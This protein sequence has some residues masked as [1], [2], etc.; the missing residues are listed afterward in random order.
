M[1]WFDQ[2]IAINRLV[3]FFKKD[4][5]KVEDFGNR[6]NQTFEAATFAQTIKW[7]KDKG[8][9]VVIMNPGKGKKKD[10]RLKFSTRGDTK[11][12]TYVICHKADGF[13]SSVQIRHQ[14]RIETYHNIRRK[15]I[16]KR[17]NIVC[18][19]AILNNCSYDHIVGNMHVF[20]DDCISFGEAKHM[21][22][23]AELIAG[24]IGIV[25]EMQPWRL[26]NDRG[27]KREQYRDHPPPFLNISGI[28]C[29]TAE[30]IKDTIKRRKFDIDIFD[31][32]R[33]FV[34]KF[35]AQR[36]GSGNS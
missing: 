10:F 8:W 1:S 3:D 28:C 4:G 25:H 26:S 20:K 11:N 15:L 19:V 33:P 30:A 23:Y 22:A 36:S 29:N 31:S 9:D 17:A 14:I 5:G 7:Y 21:D 27:K 32:R 13:P 18:D 2:K 16:S 34:E 35:D 12:F 24:F 6:I